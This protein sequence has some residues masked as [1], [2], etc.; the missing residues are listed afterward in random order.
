MKAWLI[1]NP[2]AGQRSADNDLDQAVRYLR[3][4]GWEI[5]VLRTRGSGD[6]MRY[7]Q[8]AAQRGIDMI[9]S[10][11][12]DGTLG[13]VANGLV[14]SRCALGV[15]PIGT[16]NV[17]A[18][19]L[20]FPI[21]TPVYRSALLDA[22][23]ILIEGK[24]RWIDVGRAGGRYFVLW[25]GVGF[26]AQVAQNVE[27][28]RAI[29]RNWGNLAYWVAAV[30]ESLSLRGT[31]ATVTVDGTKVR[32]RVLLVLVSNARLY[33]PSLQ[34]TPEA[35][36]DDGLLDV[37][38]FEGGNALDVIRHV[39][40]LAMGRH[41]HSSS[42]QIYRATEIEIETDDPLPLHTDGDP[43]GQTPISVSV[44]PHALQVV[45]PEQASAS[46]FSDGKKE[47]SPPL[48]IRRRIRTRL[49]RERAYLR[50]EAERIRVRLEKG[51]PIDSSKAR[52]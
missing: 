22:A 13:E 5:N 11:G 45:V 7:A 2:V 6:A 8:E 23:R 38:I 50:K 29:R 47:T 16:G 49:E 37:Y 3:M 15:L 34:L 36:L 28:R 18:R 27:P 32:R 24:R 44:I 19:M 14:A 35:C 1:H 30:A 46:L 52:D 9:I 51:L 48:S 12:G 40:L 4:R 26:D 17:W 10:A 42:I 39:V 43:M 41:V 21:W 25:M 31:P 20:G 33:G